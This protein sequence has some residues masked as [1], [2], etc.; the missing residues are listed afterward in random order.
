MWTKKHYRESEFLFKHR[1]L[2]PLWNWGKKIHT[3]KPLDFLPNFLFRSEN[4]FSN[5]TSTSMKICEQILKEDRTK[6]LQIREI[7][8]CKKGDRLNDS[9]WEVDVGYSLCLKNCPSTIL[10][11][12]SQ[13]QRNSE[14]NDEM[15]AKNTF[16]KWSTRNG[17]VWIKNFVFEQ[18]MNTIAFT[19]YEKTRNSIQYQSD[20]IKLM[21]LLKRKFIG[22][23]KVELSQNAVHHS[24]RLFDLKHPTTH[25]YRGA[26]ART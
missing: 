4:N 26:R 2:T 3:A 11:T 9:P 18:L 7:L 25:S 14:E 10:T 19:D 20:K 23:N 17:T 12:A 6:T 13:R 24:N 21:Y 8:N 5:L 16:K 22:K 15:Q 1:F